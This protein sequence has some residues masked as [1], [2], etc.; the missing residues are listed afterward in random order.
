VFSS[1]KSFHF[2][3]YKQRSST[4]KPRIFLSIINP[5]HSRGLIPCS[6][7]GCVVVGGNGAVF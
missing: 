4:E 2:C 5:D 3:I 7:I 6:L 1:I